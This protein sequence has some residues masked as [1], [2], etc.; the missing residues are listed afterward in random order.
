VNSLA[1]SDPIVDRCAS[2]GLTLARAQELA[3]EHDANDPD[4]LA[5]VLGLD[6]ETLQ[7]VGARRWIWMAAQG[8]SVS[9]SDM[10]NERALVDAIASGIVPEKYFAHICTLLDEVPLQVVVMAC[11]Q[12]SQHSQI[13]MTAIWRNVEVL[14]RM[15]GCGR[16]TFWEVD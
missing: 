4:S 13:S 16:A 7:P 14:A 9:Y 6:T 3:R 12:V 15:A 11:C 8:A 2:L 5:R 1:G 10:L